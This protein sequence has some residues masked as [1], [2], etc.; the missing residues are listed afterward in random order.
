MAGAFFAT[1]ECERLHR[2]SFRF[3]AEVRRGVLRAKIASTGGLEPAPDRRRSGTLESMLSDPTL[4]TLAAAALRSL[5]EGSAIH[6]GE[7]REAV[8]MAMRSDPAPLLEAVETQRHP[9]VG[10]D[11]RALCRGMGT[12]DAEAVCGLG[13]T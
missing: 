7:P 8:S 11:V 13:R 3:R 6:P 10:C 9:D 12:S 5:I 2:R 4:A 1:R